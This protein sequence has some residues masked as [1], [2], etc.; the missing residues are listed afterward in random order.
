MIRIIIY[1]SIFVITLFSTVV[2][3]QNTQKIPC[4]AKEYSQFNFWLGNW[5]VYNTDGKLI[6]TN[7]VVNIPNACGIQENWAS[8][9][10]PSQGTSYNYY[11]QNDNSW[12]QLWIDN[13]GFSLELK[14]AFKNN[15]MILKSPVINSKKGNYYNVVTWTKNDDGSV[16]QVWDY[17]SEEHKKIKEVFRGIY[18]KKEI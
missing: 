9:T 7:N 17:M 3:A 5:E 12:N 13:S 8:K 2:S 18:K 6:G 15:Q 14:G 11:N 1:I 10:S 16:T 4:T